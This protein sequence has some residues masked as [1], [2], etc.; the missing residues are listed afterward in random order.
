MPPA[1]SPAGSV[2]CRLIALHQRRI[3]RLRKSDV[4]PREAIVAHRDR[5]DG[6]ARGTTIPAPSPSRGSS[7][8]RRRA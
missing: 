8:A 5:D 1:I 4:Q 3:D 2:G 6:D 7:I